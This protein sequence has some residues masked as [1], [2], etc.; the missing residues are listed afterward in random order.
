MVQFILYSTE[1]TVMNYKV[2]QHM[3]ATR[4]QQN[5]QRIVRL[6]VPMVPDICIWFHDNQT[7]TTNMINKIK[8]EKSIVTKKD[9]D[10]M[11]D[12]FKPYGAHKYLTDY[13]FNYLCPQY[14]R[15]STTAADY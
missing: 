3:I 7:T 11:S 14:S 4:P 13:V 15:T 6:T 1:Q 10:E 9:G 8:N 12:V 5:R 2:I